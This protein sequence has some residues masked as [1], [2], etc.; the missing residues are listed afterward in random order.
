MSPRAVA[1]AYQRYGTMCPSPMDDLLFWLFTE[2]DTAAWPGLAPPS[3]STLSIKPGFF[4][5]NGVIMPEWVALRTAWVQAARLASPTQ[6][7]AALKDKLVASVQNYVDAVGDDFDSPEFIHF[8]IEAELGT[9]PLAGQLLVARDP[10]LID[11]GLTF[12]AAEKLWRSLAPVGGVADR[13]AIM[14]GEMLPLGGAA[15]G[16]YQAVAAELVLLSSKE[17]SH[18]DRENNFLYLRNWRSW[19]LAAALAASPT[20]PPSMFA[21]EADKTVTFYRGGTEVLLASALND[22]EMSQ[23]IAAR[24]VD[25]LNSIFLTGQVTGGLCWATTAFRSRHLFLTPNDERGNFLLNLVYLIGCVTAGVGFASWAW[26]TSRISSCGF[27]EYKLEHAPILTIPPPQSTPGRVVVLSVDKNTS[28]VPSAFCSETSWSVPSRAQL[29]VPVAAVA[30]V[31]CLVFR[32]AIFAYG[33]VKD[34][35]SVARAATVSAGSMVIAAGFWA[36]MR[37]SILLSALLSI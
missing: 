32:D 5:R 27:L 21:A 3:L 37:I 34:E 17:A 20:C 23:S 1:V 12:R 22:A 14:V 10:R 36:A 19:L 4:K 25:L 8:L 13:M 15:A 6:P 18:I 7:G 26:P 9:A 16:S 2:A 33:D 24:R 30:F 31:A 29:Q 11:N 28:Q 35:A